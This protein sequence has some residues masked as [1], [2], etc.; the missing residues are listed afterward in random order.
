MTRPKK[1]I[2]S[3]DFMAS[4]GVVVGITSSRYLMHKCL[5][6]AVH[7]GEIG[8]HGFKGRV[9][10][11]RFHDLEGGSVVGG[12]LVAGGRPGLGEEI[13]R[14]GEVGVWINSSEGGKFA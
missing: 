3:L 13:L 6:A 7:R 2:D 4:Q 10:E 8:F 1:G 9:L 12:E 14:D 11:P 5:K